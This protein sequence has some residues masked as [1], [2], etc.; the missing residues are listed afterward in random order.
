MAFQFY[1]GRR[2]VELTGRKA[3]TLSELLGHLKEVSASSVFYHTHQRYLTH[4]FRNPSF[5][6]DF[7]EWVSRALQE[8]A[9]AE[10]LAAVDVLEYTSLEGLR[11]ALVRAIEASLGEADD[12]MVRRCPRGDE[13]HFC[14]VK[15]FI[16]P[17][18]L[19]AENLEEFTNLLPKITNSSTFF[20]FFE[21]RLRL[22]RKTNDFSM[23]LEGIGERRLADEIDRIDPY[24]MTLGELRHQIYVL[25][26]RRLAEA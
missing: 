16:M 10:R 18:G 7:A 23:W 2:L 3:R 17:T 8:E 4:H 24:A 5:N 11:A 9:A 1:T 22:E 26:R 14:K 25:C 21:A 12:G 13:F 15:S 6:N 20:H 19:V